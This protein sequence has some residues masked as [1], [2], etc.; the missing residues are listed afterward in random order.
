M[1]IK[2]LRRR[3][4]FHETDQMGIIHHSNY[5]KW[6]EEARVDFM[7]QIGFGYPKAIESG[8][9]F[10]VLD[11]YCKYRSMVRFADTVEIHAIIKDLRHSRLTIG[12][13]ITDA[14]SG[15]LRAEGYTSHCFYDNRRQRPVALIKAVPELY[16]LFSELKES[17]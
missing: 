7:E 10:A 3:A 14:A 4:N 9:D 1:T 17:E 12:Y 5:I 13:I 6:F 16:R 15:K 8:I 11:T 2:P